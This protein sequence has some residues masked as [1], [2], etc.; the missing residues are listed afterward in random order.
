MAVS[1]NRGRLG[2]II[3]PILP[4]HSDLR[5]VDERGKSKTC[6]L[7]GKTC[8]F[9][10][11]NEGMT[12]TT[13]PSG[14]FLSGNPLPVHSQHPEGHSLRST[15]KKRLVPP[16][17]GKVCASGRPTVL[18]ETGSTDCIHHCCC[19]NFL[20]RR[21]V[22]HEAGSLSIAPLGLWNQ[23]KVRNARRETSLTWALLLLPSRAASQGQSV[24]IAANTHIFRQGCVCLVKGRPEPAQTAS[25]PCRSPTSLLN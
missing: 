15:S 5:V 1:A 6:L 20:Q 13:C 18:W 8:W 21:T 4:I 19:S 17:E 9:S 12:P 7:P 10:A 3:L 23:E 16:A 24:P 14:G 11:G 2:G 25:E 22:A